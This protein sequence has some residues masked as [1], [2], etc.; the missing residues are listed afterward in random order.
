[1]WSPVKLGRKEQV[2]DA[3]SRSPKHFHGGP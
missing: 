1:V 2:A 3:R